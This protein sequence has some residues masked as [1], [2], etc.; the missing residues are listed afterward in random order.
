M[1]YE[2]PLPCSQE[3]SIVPILS[4]LNLVYALILHVIQTGSEAHP[5][6]YPMGTGD[7]FPG[8]KVAGAWSWPLTSN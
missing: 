5:T 2:Y 6:S 1:E 3:P 4:Q 7:F 8:G